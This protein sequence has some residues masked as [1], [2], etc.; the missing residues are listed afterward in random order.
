[1]TQSNQDRNFDDISE[2]FAKKVYGGL[3][4]EI[5]LAVLRRDIFDWV[6]AQNRPLRVLDVGAGLAQ[7]SIEL[8]QAGHDVTVND[9][10]Q[11]MLELAKQQAH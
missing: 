10:S 6:Q 9:I 8:A 5:R 1:M 2:H 3:K 7:L 11:N 4:G